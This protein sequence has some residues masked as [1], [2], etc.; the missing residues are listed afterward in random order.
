MWNN[1]KLNKILLMLKF[2]RLLSELGVNVRE[3]NYKNIS[4]TLLLMGKN[5]EENRVK[6]QIKSLFNINDL[7]NIYF[8]IETKFGKHINEYIIHQNNM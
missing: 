7:E 6:N 4:C 3:Y 8:V 2:R 5:L 1:N